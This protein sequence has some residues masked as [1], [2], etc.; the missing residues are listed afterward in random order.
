MRHGLFRSSSSNFGDVLGAIGPVASAVE[1]AL[2]ALVLWLSAILDAMALSSAVETLVVSRRRT[3]FALS[4][5]LL[6]P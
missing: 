5:L 4:F 1:L 3:P 2:V 6:I